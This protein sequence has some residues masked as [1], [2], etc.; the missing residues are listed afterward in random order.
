MAFAI[1]A[2]RYG[3]WAPNIGTFVKIAVVGIFTILFIVFLARHGRPAGVSGP[4]GPEA[5]GE[6]VPYGDRG[7]GLPVGGL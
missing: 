7:A 5:V 2:F 3:K 1:I 6:R 4:G